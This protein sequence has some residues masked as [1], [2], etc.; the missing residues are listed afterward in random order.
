ML[1]APPDQV[2]TIMENPELGSITKPVD[3][4]RLLGFPRLVG[5]NPQQAPRGRPD[6]EQALPRALAMAIDKDTLLATAYGGQGQVAGS[7]MP[8]GVPVTS[9][10]SGSSTMSR[11]PRP[12]WLRRSRSLASATSR[13]C[14]VLSFGF[15]T[16][17]G[18]DVPAAYM[19]DQWLTNLGVKS[20]LKGV[21]FDQFVV[22]RPQLVYSIARNA[23]GL[24]Y[25]H[26][27]SAL[28]VLFH[29]KSG[30]NDE[31]QQP[32]VRQADR[33][34]RRAAHRGGTADLR[35][36]AGAARRG[37]TSGVHPLARQQLRDPSVGDRAPA[38]RPGLRELR[39]PLLRR[40][41]APRALG[42]RAFKLH[43]GVVRFAGPPRRIFP[44][45]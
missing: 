1:K 24:D 32:R 6:R 4:L 12:S 38:H 23:W 39:R 11:R 34:G 13:S 22:E 45:Q 37:L 43:P 33:S 27:D 5:G 31:V 18:H 7:P 26:P 41:Q 44:G 8:P 28:R 29:S 9:P 35:P 20:E 21:T 36:G 15:N 40:S 3:G 10:T 19:Q 25:P 17:A 30:N 42:E 2:P 14:P 16:E